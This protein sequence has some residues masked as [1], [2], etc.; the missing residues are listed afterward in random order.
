MMTSVLATAASSSASHRLDPAKIIQAAENLARS[1]DDKFPGSD[2]ASLTAALAGIAR[3]TDERVRE[4]LRPIYAIRAASFLA[5]GISLL[6]LWYLVRHIRTRFEFGT[7]TE[8]FE[9]TDAGFNLLILLA[10]ALWFLITFEGRVKRKKALE[11]IGELREFIH[12]IDTT[13]L[14]Y[15][16]DL[17]KPDRAGS[18]S[19]SDLDH[20]YLLLCGQMVAVISNLASI[21][22]RGAPGDSVL[23]AASDV[24]MLANAIGV[25]L[26]SKAKSVRVSSATG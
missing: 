1:V 5:T 7:I 20:T 16:P 23:R 6:A 9:S 15:T 18:P 17:Y 25:K 8:V 24:E 2:L 13:Q 21:Y 10:G 19:T 4:A 3:A 26:L 14:Y 22:A 12:V 11:F